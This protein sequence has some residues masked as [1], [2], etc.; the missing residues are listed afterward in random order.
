VINLSSTHQNIIFTSN[1]VYFLNGVAYDFYSLD[2]LN[3]HS[4]PSGQWKTFPL[5]NE[6]LPINI[7][8]WTPKYHLRNETTSVYIPISLKT[9]TGL[10]LVDHIYITSTPKLTDR[11]ANL[12]RM[13]TRYQITNYEWRMKWAQ[14]T[15]YA[16]ENQEEVSRKLN[17]RAKSIRKINFFF[18]A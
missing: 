2:E 17:L 10:A 4:G 1:K 13:F 9:S 6:Q 3:N 16:P 15:C 18:H 14:D 7:I 11:Q 12:E 5:P 8:P